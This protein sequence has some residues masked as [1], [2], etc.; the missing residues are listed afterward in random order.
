MVLKIV[1]ERREMFFLVILWTTLASGFCQVSDDKF[2][3]C[4]GFSRLISSVFGGVDPNLK[5]MLFTR[6]DAQDACDLQPTEE[7]FRKCNFN[8]NHKTAIIVHGF[9]TQLTTNSPLFSIKDKLL[10][11]DDYNVVVFN[12]TAYSNNIPINVVIS[13]DFSILN[14]FYVAYKLS[15][16]MHFL[17][18]HGADT[19]HFHLIGHSLGCSLIHLAV[20]PVCNLGHI[21]YLDAAGP[22]YKSLLILLQPMN[23]DAYFVDS[24]HTDG[25]ITDKGYGLRPP[26]ADIDYYPNGGPSQSK[27]VPGAKY[28]TENGE[29][30]TVTSGMEKNYCS[31]D[32]CFDYYIASFNKTCKFLGRI[33]DSY[34]DFIAGKCSSAPVCRMGF[35]SKKIPNL[36]AHSK[37]YLKTSAKFPYCLD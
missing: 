37:C 36:P 26:F 9:I 6:S 31:H 11:V 3:F 32:A 29:I 21:T 19:K 13:Y 8:P 14:T 35:Y 25:T 16:W 34:E 2:S 4:G 5:Y 20:Q 15:S 12:W 1:V 7:A 28:R 30:D 18:L 10:Q 17:Q 27:C 23:T 33:C 24:I 22:L